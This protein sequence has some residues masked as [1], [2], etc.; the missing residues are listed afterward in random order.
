LFPS[1]KKA[2]STDKN[3]MLIPR[4]KESKEPKYDLRAGRQ[5]FDKE[6][7]RH[8]LRM[9][10]IPKDTENPIDTRIRQL[11]IGSWTGQIDL[12]KE[13]FDKWAVVITKDLEIKIGRIKDLYMDTRDIYIKTR[14]GDIYILPFGNVMKVSER[15]P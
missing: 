10:T 9:A 1:I 13:F 2:N 11:I 15:E 8:D 14:K 7:T 6:Y 3:I 4:F 5:I 12:K